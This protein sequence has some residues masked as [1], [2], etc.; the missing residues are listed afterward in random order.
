[1]S[2][3]LH[4]AFATATRSAFAAPLRGGFVVS[5]VGADAWEAAWQQVRP[6]C[7][8]RERGPQDTP[9]T[10]DELAGFGALGRSLAP[11]PLR[12]HLVI[13]EAGG[14]LVGVSRGAQ[15][16]RA[17]WCMSLTAI[18]PA[19]QRQGIYSG[20]LSRL[21]PLLRDM[22]FRQVT[23]HHRADNS[24]VLVPKLKAGFLVTGVQ[25]SPISGLMVELTR[26]LSEGLAAAYRSRIDADRDPGEP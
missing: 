2:D 6:L 5:A 11:R 15:R 3:D 14:E 17:D 26:P 7:A 4:S 12:H 16:L 23:S 8:M 9:Y 19:F 18:K 24:A 21:L 22:G 1:M 25:V 10:A 13:H 20:L